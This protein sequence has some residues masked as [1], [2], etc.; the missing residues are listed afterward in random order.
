MGEMGGVRENTHLARGTIA[1]PRTWGGGE[2]K[3][4][5]AWGLC[6]CGGGGGVLG[7]EGGLGRV[8]G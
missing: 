3:G 7:G 5:G 6:V 2:G 4:G 8:G 1:S